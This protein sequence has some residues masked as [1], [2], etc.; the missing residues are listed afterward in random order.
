MVK[1]GH[2]DKHLYTIPALRR[3]EKK[4]GQEFKASLC[5]LMSS[6]ASRVAGDSAS[7]NQPGAGEMARCL[8]TCHSSENPRCGFQHL[9]QVAHNYLHLQVI[10]IHD[11][12][13]LTQAHIETPK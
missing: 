10:C 9:D 13:K 4:E 6:K 7:K 5:Y 8:N 11:A 2:G 3:R 1:A 12:Y